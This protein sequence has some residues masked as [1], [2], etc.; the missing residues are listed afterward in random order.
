MAAD[1]RPAAR[2]R[3]EELA[4]KVRAG[5]LGID[6]KTL[7]V[8]AAIGEVGD[9]SG[10]ILAAQKAHGLLN[11]GK[12]ADA[13]KISHEIEAQNI[14]DEDAHY[15][16]WRCLIG[17]RREDEAEKER[18]LLATLLQSI[19]DSGDGKSVKTA[20]FATTIRETYLYMQAVLNLQ[21][22]D[23]RTWQQD[24]H[25]YDVV[26]VKDQG[27]K[28]QTLWFIA[29]TEMQRQTAAGERADEK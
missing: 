22:V 18:V 4:K 9:A 7:R 12:F 16:A 25:Y 21:Y 13:L 24:G 1:D 19:T 27:G 11:E 5:D 23:H 26:V 8:A 17:L 15:V 20:W 29:D 3:Y 28:E 10:S 6:W 14:A 2:A